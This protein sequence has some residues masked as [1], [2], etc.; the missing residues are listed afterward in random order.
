MQKSHNSI[1][2]ALELRLFCM[3]PWLYLPGTLWYIFHL[4][5]QV[6]SL[7]ADKLEKVIFFSGN[8]RKQ[9]LMDI[10]PCILIDE[11]SS[12]V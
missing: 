10:I 2:K 8:F 1:A 4:Q 7:W 5:Y 3:K 12:Y 11:K 6:I 9:N